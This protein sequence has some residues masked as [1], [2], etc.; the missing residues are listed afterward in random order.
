M[1]VTVIAPNKAAIAIYESVGFAVTERHV[2]LQPP[3]VGG[4]DRPALDRTGRMQA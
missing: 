3:A 4:I 2:V 1:N